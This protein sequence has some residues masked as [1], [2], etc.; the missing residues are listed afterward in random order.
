[1]AFVENRILNIEEVPVYNSF[2]FEGGREELNRK[3]MTEDFG[4]EIAGVQ[5][6]NY[7]LKSIKEYAESEKTIKDIYYQKQVS[8]EEGKKMAHIIEVEQSSI[9]ERH[10]DVEFLS[11]DEWYSIGMEMCKQAIFKVKE[12]PAVEDALNTTV[13]E[14]A[15]LVFKQAD[16]ICRNTFSVCMNTV[17]CCDKNDKQKFQ[18][19]E[20]STLSLQRRP[21]TDFPISKRSSNHSSVKKSISFLTA[22]FGEQSACVAGSKVK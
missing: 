11:T 15:R 12:M 21:E 19:K 4:A 7:L 14:I 1:M 22:C 3:V 13:L 8:F 17:F 16:I 5:A 20:I 18:R 2:N 6:Y 10:T 9:I